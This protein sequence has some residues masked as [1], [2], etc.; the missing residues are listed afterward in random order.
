MLLPRLSGLRTDSLKLPVTLLSCSLEMMF[1]ELLLGTVST[2]SD[3]L[4]TALSAL[5]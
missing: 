1:L 5:V 3:M 2:L 4:L